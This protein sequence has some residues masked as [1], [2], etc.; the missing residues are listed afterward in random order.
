MPVELLAIADWL[1]ASPRVNY[2]VRADELIERTYLG[3]SS[4]TIEN[5]GSSL[6][7]TGP[8][9]DAKTPRPPSLGANISMGGRIAPLL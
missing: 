1:G 3:K 9:R 8:E 7:R 6:F 4:G 2:P 5:G